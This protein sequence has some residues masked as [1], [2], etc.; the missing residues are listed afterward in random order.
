MG[1]DHARRACMYAR[2]RLLLLWTSA[3]LRAHRQAEVAH[4]SAHP[5]VDP[6]SRRRRADI[7]PR[8]GAEQDRGQVTPTAGAWPG[9]AWSSGAQPDLRGAAVM[10]DGAPPRTAVPGGHQAGARLSRSLRTSFPTFPGRMQR[11][12]PRDRTGQVGGGSGDVRP[13]GNV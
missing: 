4:D 10:L 7:R 8:K 2:L 3:A 9:E 12:K 11:F 6:A 13:G 1:A 5:P